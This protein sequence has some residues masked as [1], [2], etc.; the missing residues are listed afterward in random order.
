MINNMITFDD[1]ELNL[2][3]ELNSRLENFSIIDKLID[4]P[5]K[6]I[7]R[8]S[9]IPFR[10][11]QTGEKKDFVIGFIDKEEIC[12][13]ISKTVMEKINSEYQNKKRNHYT[14]NSINFFPTKEERKIYL[15]SF[16]QQRVK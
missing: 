13:I 12:E 4:K 7:Y 11:R 6:D 2:G 1:L 10:H 5:N 15:T 9:E 16:F 3:L 8:K 14:K